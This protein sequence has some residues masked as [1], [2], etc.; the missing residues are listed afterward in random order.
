MELAYP[1]STHKG[2]QQNGKA[3]RGEDLKIAEVWMHSPGT[4]KSINREWKPY[5]LEVF[6][7]SFSSIIGWLLSYADTRANPKRPGL[8]FFLIKRNWVETLA[9]AQYRGDIPQTWY[10]WVTE[11]KNSSNYRSLRGEIAE[12]TVATT[13]LKCQYFTKTIMRQA[14][15]KCDLYP[16]GKTIN[17]KC[18][19]VVLKVGLSRQRLQKSYYK[20]VQKLKKTLKNKGK[21]DD[22]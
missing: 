22:T 9:A 18:S 1:Q 14:K 20:Y 5:W 15:K 10:K 16:G 4:H 8:K 7:H 11:Q 19:S 6:E 12:T 17:R 13:Y 2:V 3:G 21:Y